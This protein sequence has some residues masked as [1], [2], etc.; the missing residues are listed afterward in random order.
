MELEEIW[1]IG[2]EDDEDVLLG[3]ITRALV[4]EEDN[5]YLLDQQLSEVQVFSSDGEYM[6]TLG[7]EGSGPG[8]VTRP[9]DF[10]FMPDGTLG[11]VQ[12]FPGK[13]VK[14]DL[15]GVPA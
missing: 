9:G 3:I 15:N 8:E 13:I 2:G 5:I 14:V 6:K 12:I 4:D 10:L 11:L 1:R 7:R